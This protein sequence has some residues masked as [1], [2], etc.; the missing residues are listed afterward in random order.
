MR[1]AMRIC[2]AVDFS[3]PS[4]RAMLQATELARRLGAELAL[5][6]VVEV[7]STAVATVFAG[8]DVLAERA[9]ADAER[10][11]VAWEEEAEQLTGRHVASALLRGDAASEILGFLRG[12]EFDL[13]VV[14]SDGRAGLKGLVLGSV[15]E[16]VARQA[17]CPVWIA[18]RSE[19]QEHRMDAE[20]V[21]QYAGGASRGA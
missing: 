6:H 1:E 5:V 7:P 8:R 20:E 19:A 3:D 2:C 16:R 9:G 4:R 17:P 10:A 18:R 12:S 15:A 11:L 14:G 21:A 13:L